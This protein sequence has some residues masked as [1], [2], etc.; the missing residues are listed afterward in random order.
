MVESY[1]IENSTVV[2]NNLGHILFSD[3]FSDVVIIAGGE[4]GSP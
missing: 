4:A 2:T 3:E 1:T